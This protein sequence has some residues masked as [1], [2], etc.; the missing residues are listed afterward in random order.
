MDYQRGGR[1]RRLVNR[2]RETLV[3]K[4]DNDRQRDGQC[5]ADREKHK[6]KRDKLAASHPSWLPSASLLRPKSRQ[7]LSLIPRVFRLPS[8]SVPTGSIDALSTRL[9]SFLSRSLSL[10][11]PRLFNHQPPKRKSIAQSKPAFDRERIVSLFVVDH[12]AMFFF[13]P[14]SLIGRH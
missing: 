3:G 2:D 10:S 9:S 8:K 13:F 12:A 5:C 1:R 4:L 6:S 7:H 11:R 14:Q